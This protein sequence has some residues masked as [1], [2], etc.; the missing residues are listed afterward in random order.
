MKDVNKILNGV[1]SKM[2][3]LEIIFKIVQNKMNWNH[4]YSL[5]DITREML[6]Q[7]NKISY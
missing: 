2:E 7:L 6:M 5:E 4:D 1:T 3:M